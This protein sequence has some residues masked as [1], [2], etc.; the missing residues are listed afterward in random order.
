LSKELTLSAITKLFVVLLVISSLL[1]SASVV[2]FV[3]KVEDYRAGNEK[4]KR[5]LASAKRDAE[6]AVRDLDAA[7]A[8]SVSQAKDFATREGQLN[9][10]ITD[11]DAKVQELNASL[12]QA[13]K[14][15]QVKDMTNKGISDALRASQEE[16]KGYLALNTEMR[17]KN[18]ELLKQNG[19]LNT[20]ITV[21]D[22]K[23][24][25]TDKAREYAEEHV[26]ELQQQIKNMS[27]GGGGNAA[28]GGGGS[29]LA[30]PPAINA[31][32]RA[33]DIIGGK[34]YATISVG[35]SDNVA[36]G[37]KFNIINRNTAE[38]LGSLTVDR[39][40]VNEAIGQVEGSKIDKIQPGVEA[41]TQL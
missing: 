14:D 38:Y 11:R 4:A 2:V 10:E 26:T 34:K 8:A 23:L 19:E 36:K 5:D 12:A 24:R 7:H 21:L 9:K 17:N 28:P 30:N 32:V 1:L 37:M 40:D 3:N 35:S 20:Q 18:D 31:V 22:N 25:A 39:V 27:G 13:T 15:A 41:K 29:S 6:A 33:V 16:N